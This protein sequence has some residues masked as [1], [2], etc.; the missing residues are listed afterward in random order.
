MTIYLMRMPKT[1]MVEVIQMH[2][3][4]PMTSRF[5]QLNSPFYYNMSAGRRRT[6]RAYL[7]C[8]SSTSAVCFLTCA[9]LQGGAI[10]ASFAVQ[11]PHLVA[12][13]IAL[14]ATA[15]IVEVCLPQ[16]RLPRTFS[17][18]SYTVIR[19]VSHVEIPLVAADA[20]DNLQLS[21]SRKSILPCLCPTIGSTRLTGPSHSDTSNTSPQRP[22]SSPK[23]M[24]RPP[25]APRSPNSC[26]SSP[27]TYRAITLRS[28]RASG[29][30]PCGAWRPCLPRWG[31]SSGRRRRGARFCSCGAPQTAS[32]RIATR[33]A[34]GC[35]LVRTRRG[36]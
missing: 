9:G 24:S 26:A 29:T 27:R 3:R 10:A 15:G 16:L 22:V 32:C 7:W 11:F 34:C 30:A 1:C 36:S 14:M 12:G 18:F 8:V 23:P 35:S 31:G 33:R 21:R 17:Y 5:T 20:S 13:N 19:H 6:S 4:Q 28:R 2:L 25:L